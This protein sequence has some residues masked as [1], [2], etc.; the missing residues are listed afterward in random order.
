MAMRADAVSH[1]PAARVVPCTGAPVSRPGHF[2]LACGD[3]NWYLTSLHW[4]R[5]SA[6]V[7]IAKG[8]VTLNDCTPNCAEGRY[9]S[10]SGVVVFSDPV[11]RG[12]LGELFSV[13]TVLDSK[14]L[15]GS[16]GTVTSQALPLRVAS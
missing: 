1:A 16:N 7:G 2:V 4:I 13:V 14:R 10:T 8:T 11:L 15:P 9:H 3:G 5:W 12:S 6:D